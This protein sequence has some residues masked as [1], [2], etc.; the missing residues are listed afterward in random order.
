MERDNDKKDLNEDMQAIKKIIKEKNLRAEF[1]MVLEREDISM[2]EKLMDL[3]LEAFQRVTLIYAVFQNDDLFKLEDSQLNG[4]K[5]MVDE[6]HTL[7]DAAV[8]LHFETIERR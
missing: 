4:V 8:G 3:V 6:I 5:T 1:T 7:L 2:R